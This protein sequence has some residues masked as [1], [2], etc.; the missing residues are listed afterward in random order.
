[1]SA[2]PPEILRVV[3]ATLVDREGRVL[4]AQR[5]PGKWQAG[6]WEFPGGKVEPG[7]TE[8]DAVRRELAEELGVQV[9]AA[10]WLA[11]FRHDY[12]DRSVSIGLW[13]VLRHDG[14]PRGLD[15]QAL[16][17]VD[18]PRLPACDLLEADLP[19]LP[20]LRA[21]LGIVEPS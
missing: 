21:A 20:V 14:V 7:E 4:I 6:R 1:M 8:A 9:H 18:A 17:W 5:P 19:M 12:P 11:E 10:E 3:A 15:G 16:R 2:C 13:L